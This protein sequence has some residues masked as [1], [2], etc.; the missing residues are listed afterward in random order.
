M[1]A[2]A[3][4]LDVSSCF[5]GFSS[6][7]CPQQAARLTLAR[8]ASTLLTGEDTRRAA[9]AEPAV[10]GRR[11]EAGQ[12]GECRAD[13]AGGKQERHHQARAAVR[14][15]FCAGG[16]RWCRRMCVDRVY[17]RWLQVL[18]R[19]H[20]QYIS[21]GARSAETGDLRGGQQ[22]RRL[23]CSSRRRR[24]RPVWHAP[25]LQPTYSSCSLFLHRPVTVVPSF[26]ASASHPSNNGR[27]CRDVDVANNDPLCCALPAF[28]LRHQA[29][30]CRP[31]TVHN[32]CAYVAVARGCGRRGRSAVTTVH[33]CIVVKRLLCIV[34]LPHSSFVHYYT[35]PR[36][37]TAT[38]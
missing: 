9:D 22:E 25:L 27:G 24:H 5:S 4:G 35:P 3:A 20:R 6:S 31:A 38:T 30:G 17:V 36:T 19:Y 8:A 26:S 7:S 29:A 21:S 16:N 10:D 23:N 1:C 14:K 2:V 28:F 34:K 37:T 18:R 33:P 11:S 15:R 32:S 12:G 13:G